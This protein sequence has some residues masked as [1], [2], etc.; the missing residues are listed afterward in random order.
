MHFALS[1]QIGFKVNMGI[2]LIC[3]LKGL[4]PLV[5]EKSFLCLNI[6]KQQGDILGT[7]LTSEQQYQQFIVSLL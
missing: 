1:E 4:K 5:F 6:L 7:E 3:L 2:I